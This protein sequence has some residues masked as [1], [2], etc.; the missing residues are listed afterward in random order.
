MGSCLRVNRGR[1]LRMHGRAY[2]RTL[3]PSMQSDH[4]NSQLR[5]GNSCAVQTDREGIRDKVDELGRVY[6]R[7]GRPRREKRVDS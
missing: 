6:H 2:G 1:S 4:K 5:V 3:R 7:R